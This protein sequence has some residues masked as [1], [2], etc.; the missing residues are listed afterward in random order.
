[1]SKSIGI[2]EICEP[3]HYSA[4]NGL[5]KTYA[6]DSSNKVY[7]FTIPKIK[8]ALEENGV[9]PNIELVEWNKEQVPAKDFLDKVSSYN[10]DRLHVCTVAGYYKDF[11][12]FNPKAQEIYFHVH[13]IDLWF[14]DTLS[15]AWDSMIFDLKNNVSNRKPYRIVGRFLLETLFTSRHRKAFLQNTKRRNHQF[16]VHSDG[17]K[18]F[19]SQ[20][21]PKEKITVFPFAIY[22][23]MQD[24]SMENTKLRIC[25]PGIIT[26]DRREYQ[27]LFNALVDNAPALKDKLLIDLLGFIPEPEK[28]EMG[29]KIRKV[30]EA[31]IEMIYYPTFVFGKQFDESLS[32]ADVLLNNQKVEKNL[33]SKYGVTKESGMI[34]NMLRGAKVGI[35]PAA[36]QV[37]EEFK[38]ST[39]F[40]DDYT[41]LGQMIAEMVEN[42][43]KVK[44]LKNKAIELSN[45]YSPTSLYKR[46]K[47]W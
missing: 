5:M 37:N 14:N 4:V 30:Q 29:G 2:L 1:M 44:T 32:K 33:T 7:V 27:L 35:I 42:P 31:G 43:N 23:G 17:Q 3:N 36:Y 38:P 6:S 15:R 28:E 34:F 41:H 9:L 40:F 45:M 47:T 26:E 46:L 10:L 39:L 12:V 18:N 25:I 24:A 21:V 8:K 22:E 19:F 13:N 16:I 11:A 20:Y